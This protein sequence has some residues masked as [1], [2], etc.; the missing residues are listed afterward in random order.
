VTTT[1]S[2]PQPGWE[3]FCRVVDNYGDIGVCLRLARAL[4]EQGGLGVRLWVDD[5]DALARLCPQALHDG[6][7]IG[8]VEFRRWRKV[9]RV[10]PPGEVVIE[11]F[12]C[13]LPEEHVQAMAARR[14]PSLWINL[15]YLSAEDWVKT[16]HGL[17]SPPP[18]LPSGSKLRKYFFFPG[19]SADSGGL[20]R[21][22]G[23][24]AR[25][26]ALRAGSRAD[27]L[28]ARGFEP[29]REDA[30]W[31][32]LFAYGQPTIGNLLRLWWQGEEPVLLLVPEGRVVADVAAALEV[33]LEVGAQIQRGA[34]RLVVLP[35]SDQDGYDELLW[36]CDLDLVRGEDSFVRAQWAAR[37]FVWQIYPQEA[38]AHFVKLDAFLT[39]Y[40]ADLDAETAA[41]LT[42]FCM[43]WNGRGDLAASWQGFR[44]ALPALDIHARRWCGKLGEQDDLV[45]RL[46]EFSARAR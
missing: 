36:A 2:R 20:I 43:A 3:I 17:A 6:V 27:W 12:G 31:V 35:F 46:G 7:N 18:G 4:A 25:R 23:L 34:L 19:F 37:P 1:F 13:E 45:C 40:C 44:K 15:E 28:R 5:W 30:L 14:P 24:F 33:R 39:L 16:C 8:G 38:G 21:E 29:W 26:D 10:M 41:A 32:S 42:A 11:A 22:A 9:F